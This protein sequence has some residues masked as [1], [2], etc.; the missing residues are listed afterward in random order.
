[1]LFVTGATG[2]LGQHLVSALRA[3][4]EQLRLLVRQPQ[5]APATFQQ[6][7]I[8]LVEGDLLDT[9]ALLAGMEG[10]KAV[11][12]AAAVVSFR[13]RDWRLMHNINPGG[14]AHVVNCMLEQQVPR[15]VLVSSIAALSRKTPGETLDETTPWRPSRYNS[16]YG[17]SKYLSEL[18]AYRGF[19]EGLEIG[20]V[21]P[22]VILGPA[23]SWRRSSPSIVARAAQGK[24]FAP[25]G[26]NGFVGVQ[27]VVALIQKLLSHPLPQPRRFIAVSEN[28]PYAQV[29][30]AL[31]L[32]LGGRPPTQNLPPA[33][34]ELAGRVLHHLAP[35][36]PLGLEALRNTSYAFYYNNERAR[37]ELKHTFTP[38][39]QVLQQTAQA[40]QAQQLSR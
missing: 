30:R 28:L 2:F 19:E 34:A 40:Y 39:S 10:C 9:S 20:V 15:L 7:G 6:E 13:R 5:Q 32:E 11:V 21:N 14:T 1:M 16:V 18:E 33:V 17:R 8:E 22:G 35:G 23:A 4:G 36:S 27:D 29:L 25:A 38:M 3:S 26:V 12:H 24:R 31:A 37:Q